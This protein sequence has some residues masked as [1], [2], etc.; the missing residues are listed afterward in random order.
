MEGMYPKKKKGE[1]NAL[2]LSDIVSPTICA[3]V[4]A[5]KKKKG[6]E[7]KSHWTMWGEA[8]N[9]GLVFFPLLPWV[10]PLSPNEK[11]NVNDVRPKKE[12]RHF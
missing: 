7:V 3:F 12:K 11:S 8:T 5:Q 6:A 9:G 10:L 2:F 4:V 1:P